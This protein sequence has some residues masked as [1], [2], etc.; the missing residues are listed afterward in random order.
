MRH[1]P[2]ACRYLDVQAGSSVSPIG[3]A[4]CRSPTVGNIG[5]WFDRDS[6]RGSEGTRGMNSLRGDL[7][8]SDSPHR[9]AS[10]DT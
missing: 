1:L 6:A 10:G 3:A 5:R 2:S 8:I 7:S 4:V 9:N